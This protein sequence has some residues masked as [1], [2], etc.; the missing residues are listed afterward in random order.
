MLL[1]DM[2]ILL[3]LFNASVNAVNKSKSS[4]EMAN[5]KTYM[6]IRFPLAIFVGGGF[7][8]LWLEW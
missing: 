1:V 5:G 4:K 3:T 6:N 2:K 8:N 7:M